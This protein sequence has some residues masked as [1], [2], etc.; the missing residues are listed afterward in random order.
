MSLKFE[1]RNILM[2]S[3]KLRNNR[4]FCHQ[5]LILVIKLFNSLNMKATHDKY[6]IHTC[7]VESL[8]LL[9]GDINSAR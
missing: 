6:Q 3:T 7:P 5:S 4:R 1:G 8:K 9:Q 2:A